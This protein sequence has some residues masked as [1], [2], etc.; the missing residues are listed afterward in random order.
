VFSDEMT[1][2]RHAVSADL[3]PVE[4]RRRRRWQVSDPYG[5]PR[6]LAER[7]RRRERRE[8]RRGAATLDEARDG[9][10]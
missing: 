6:L 9:C 2:T 1:F 10:S 3:Q 8:Q 5:D 4:R 7:R